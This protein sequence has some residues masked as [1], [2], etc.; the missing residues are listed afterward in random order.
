MLFL[1]FCF[2]LFFLVD[3]F[4]FIFSIFF[5]IVVFDFLG[6]SCLCSL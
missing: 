3:W 2:Y 1:W 6:Y 5:V 4:L